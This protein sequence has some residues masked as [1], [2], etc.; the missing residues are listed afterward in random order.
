MNTLRFEI[1][2]GKAKFAPFYTINNTITNR[3]REQENYWHIEFNNSVYKIL[4]HRLFP[5]K[6]NLSQGNGN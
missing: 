5:L 4:F 1:K 2:K 3:R 6:I